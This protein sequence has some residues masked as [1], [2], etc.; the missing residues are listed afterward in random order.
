MIDAA[1]EGDWDRVVAVFQ[2]H[3]YTRTAA[4]WRDFADA[5]VGADAVVLTDVYRRGEQPQPGRVGRL[6][7]QAVLD[8]HPEQAG[9]LPPAPRRPRRARARARAARRRRA[10]ARRRRPHDR[11]R[12]VAGAR[13]DERG[14]HRRR[15]SRSSWSARS[16][17]RSSATSPVADAHHLPRWAG[18]SRCWSRAGSVDALAAVAGWSREH[19]PPLLVVGR[20]S[21]LLVADAGF[22]G[23]GVVLA[24]DVRAR[25]TS[26]PTP[27][28]VRA[29]GAVPLPSS[30]AAAAAAGGRASSSSSGSPAASAARCG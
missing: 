4:L 2:P 9:R 23:L 22:A 12:R 7:L 13:G 21:N 10:D 18:R 11:A 27:G 15:R 5:F 14:G 16:R 17:A 8:A 1:R 30:P 20:G 29:G 19:A 6:V 24:G 25:S 28:V 26:T 3:R